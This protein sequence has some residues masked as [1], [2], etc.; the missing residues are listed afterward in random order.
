MIDQHQQAAGA[1]QRPMVGAERSP[2]AEPEN[3]PPVSSLVAGLGRG[4]GRGVRA[5][6]GARHLDLRRVSFGVGVRKSRERDVLCVPC[7]LYVS[8]HACVCS[9]TVSSKTLLYGG[10]DFPSILR[11]AIVSYSTACLPSALRAQDVCWCR[12]F[13]SGACSYRVLVSLRWPSERAVDLADNAVAAGHK[14][15]GARKKRRCTKVTNS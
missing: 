10:F 2:A 3:G 1:R 9:P 4:A 8:K 15:T 6:A 13:S 11:P 7:C 5:A 14:A 12:R